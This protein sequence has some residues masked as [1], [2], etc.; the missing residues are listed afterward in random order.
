M[1]NVFD[2]IKEGYHELHLIV[3][4]DKNG[5]I[6]K[7]NELPWRYPADL[8]HFKE[9]TLN[10]PVIMGSK[11]WNSIPVKFRP[12]EKRQNIVM[13]KS[14][15]P[16]VIETCFWECKEI[17]KAGTL[18][19][20]SLESAL[21]CALLNQ[22]KAFIIGGT[23]VYKQCLDLGIVTHMTLTRINKEHEGDVYFPEYDEDAFELIEERVGGKTGLLT[24]QWWKRK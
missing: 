10:C 18:V 4:M 16:R 2:R 24:F 3:A 20:D 13:S 11:T 9:E 21:D 22:D 14:L 1:S 12:L 15:E 19:A 23:S 5:L 7:G 17:K 8:K 6:G